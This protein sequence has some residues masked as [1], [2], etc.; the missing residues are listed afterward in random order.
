M[1]VASPRLNLLQDNFLPLGQPTGFYANQECL[2]LTPQD[3]GPL[4]LASWHAAADAYLLV[5]RIGD[6][7]WLASSDNGGVAKAWQQDGI[8]CFERRP[9]NG[10]DGQTLSFKLAPAIV[11]PDGTIA[12]EGFRYVLQLEALALPHLVP[13]LIN[14]MLAWYFYELGDLERAKMYYAML[15]KFAPNDK[16]TQIVKKKL[17]PSPFGRLVSKFMSWNKH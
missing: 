5:R 12:F 13:G 8:W 11:K 4:S 1:P 2:L 15:N 7:N 6:N 10:A 3:Q 9:T 16:K 14:S 17:F